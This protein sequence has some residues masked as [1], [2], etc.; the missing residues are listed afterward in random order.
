MTN[1]PTTPESTGEVAAPAPAQSIVVKWPAVKPIVTY[2]LIAICVILYA[3][4]YLS[5]L[6][7]GFDLPFALGG[8]I[9]A[10]ITAGELW[11]LFSPMFLHGSIIH[12]GL[13]MYA[14]IIL[15]RNIEQAFGHSRFTALFIAA[16]FAGNVLSYVFSPNPSLGSSTAIFGLLGA[17][18]VFV[19]LNRKFF[20]ARSKPILINAAVVAGIN[21]VLGL[22]PGIDNWGHLGGLLGGMLF[23]LLACPRWQVTGYL[24]DVA[25]TDSRP[26]FSTWVG[27]GL[28]LALF[29]GAILISRLLIH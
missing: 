3:G 7:L 6:L 24:P 4:Q 10:A 14:L 2:T 19:Y 25:I 26:G 29:S 12:L 1:P 9:N 13:N 17:E 16:G 11:R 22:S 18:A 23:A 8:K 5:Q 15:G 27:F 21:L 20:G 28:V